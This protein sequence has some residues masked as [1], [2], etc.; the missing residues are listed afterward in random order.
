MAQLRLHIRS[1]RLFRTLCGLELSALDAPIL[2]IRSF[3]R[4]R[5]VDHERIRVCAR[6][7]RAA[8]RQTVGLRP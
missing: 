1:E 4:R 8:C 2:T 3:L 7:A 6:C 5:P